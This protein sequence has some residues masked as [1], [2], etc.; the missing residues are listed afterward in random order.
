MN[1]DSPN[2]GDVNFDSTNIS[3][4]NFDLPNFGAVNF[5]SPNFGDVNF[6]LPNFVVKN[7]GANSR[8]IN[9]I[10]CYTHQFVTHLKYWHQKLLASKI[11]TPI[12]LGP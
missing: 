9:L 3:A 4:V 6:D 5:Y 11:F 7:F 8:G 10:G 12:I 2:F 1:F